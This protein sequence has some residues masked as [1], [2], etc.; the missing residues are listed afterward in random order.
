MIISRGGCGQGLFELFISKYRKTPWKST[1]RRNRM[2][3]LV[4]ATISPRPA[5]FHDTALNSTALG[6]VPCA[7]FE[8]G[9]RDAEL[10]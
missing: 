10:S 7:S 5:L 1:Q 2:V 6:R 4:T 9:E 3:I 8:F